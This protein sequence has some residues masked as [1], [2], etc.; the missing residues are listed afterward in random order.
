MASVNVFKFSYNV[1]IHCINTYTTVRVL[2]ST[3]NVYLERDSGRV[4]Q[5]ERREEILFFVNGV[6]VPSPV[7]F[8]H[9]AKLL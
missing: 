2:L 9:L 5:W 3:V 4:G 1:L 8:D 7:S 6:Q